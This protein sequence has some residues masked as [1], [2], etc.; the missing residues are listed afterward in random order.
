M[1]QP[2]KASFSEKT[3][4]NEIE[5]DM[6]EVFDRSDIKDLIH[7]I[8]S[9]LK[10]SGSKVPYIFL[11]FRLQNDDKKLSFFLQKVLQ[12]LNHPDLVKKII[13]RTDCFTLVSALKFLWCRLPNSCVIGWDAYKKFKQQ[14]KEQDYPKNAF[15]EIM[16][17]CL[18]SADHA[19]IVYDFLDLL[20]RVAA[21]TK[22]NHL[23]GRKISKMAG[24]WAFS[25]PLPKSL[26][27]STSSS[28]GFSNYYADEN[29]HSFIDGLE[30][31]LPASEATFHLLLSFLRSMLPSDTSTKVKIQRSL[32]ALLASN[33]YPPE[34]TI[35]SAH[36]TSMPLITV[37]SRKLSSDPI[38]LLARTSKTLLFDKP[39]F[40]EAIEDYVVLKHL[41]KDPNEN[42]IEKL[43]PESRKI[44]DKLCTDKKYYLLKNGW[45]QED[46]DARRKRSV[47]SSEDDYGYDDDDDDDDG[48]NVHKASVSRIAIDDYYIWAWMSSISAESS[49]A[50]RQL[51]GKTLVAEFEFQQDQVKW[52]IIQECLI[53]DGD[54]EHDLY[55]SQSSSA[56]PESLY[57]SGNTNNHLKVLQ[58]PLKVSSSSYGEYTE[59]QVSDPSFNPPPSHNSPTTTLQ[60]RSPVKSPR[61]NGS[62]SPGKSPAHSRHSYDQNYYAGGANEY[63]NN[64]NAGY[65]DYY[66]GQQPQQG[67]PPAAAGVPPPPP[68]SGA[69]KRRPPPGAG[70]PPGAALPQQPYPVASRGPPPP[71]QN[72][73]YY[74][75]QQKD[76]GDYYYYDQSY[77]QH[78]GYTHSAPPPPRHGPAPGQ[79][80]P[81]PIPGQPAR[82]SPT[83]Q[84]PPPPP[85]TYRQPPPPGAY[86]PGPPPPGAVPYRAGPGGPPPPNGYRPNS[87]P[88]L[89]VPGAQYPRYG[90]PPPQGNVSPKMPGSGATPS[91]AGAPTSQG[92][93]A[94][95]PQPM[96]RSDLTIAQMPAATS[97]NKLH[98]PS[99]KQTDKKALRSALNSGTFGI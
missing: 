67:P 75:N 78:P 87:S 34:N 97:F 80:A 13:K 72:Y 63:G 30:E 52:L 23:S 40:F 35:S 83:R 88:Q 82:Y 25:G 11:P 61:S 45:S 56:V 2:T 68:P 12:N 47:D 94:G 62:R 51:F 55:N 7:M 64:T 91:P 28:L 4:V 8:T 43:T 33:P 31:W 44:V 58:D 6:I 59:F 42:I 74:D 16:P 54:S 65:N 93:A 81:A 77:Y 36:L 73:Y 41:F 39:E 99:T 10:S 92:P 66:Y 69:I 22:E 60:A 48:F 53:S 89:G 71:A 27:E 15:L 38:E 20:V 76:G 1:D 96:T 98:G 14:E 84:G 3:F 46:E 57:S 70:P 85:G 21:Y 29:R 19:S 79:H 5:L 32:Q 9:E 24:M 49:D 26:K 37:Y 17:N 90:P 95:A 50:K 86:R 18:S